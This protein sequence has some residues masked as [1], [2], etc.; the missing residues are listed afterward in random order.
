MRQIFEVQT[1]RHVEGHVGA[2]LCETCVL[3]IKWPQWH[4]SFEGQ[5]QLNMR[6]VYPTEREENAHETGEIDL[7][8]EVGSE[9]GV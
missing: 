3:G 4:T 6:Y 7:L 5:I 9:A 1:W 8:E 2:V